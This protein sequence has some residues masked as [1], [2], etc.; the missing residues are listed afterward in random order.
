[1]AV[2][3]DANNEAGVAVSDP[4]NPTNQ[5]MRFLWQQGA[6]TQYDSNT[7][8]KAHLYGEFGPHHSAEE[9]WSFDVLF[10]SVGMEFD[11]QPAIIMQLH[12]VPDAGEAFRRPPI[13]VDNKNDRLTLSWLYD[14]RQITPAGFD[15]W[16]VSSRDLGATTKDQWINFV[17]HVKYDPW[18]DGALRVL[19]DGQLVVDESEVA[20]GFNDQLGAYLGFGIY[21]FTGT[22]AYSQRSIYFDNMRQWLVPPSAPQLTAD[23]NFSSVVNDIDLTIWEAGFSTGTTHGQGDADLDNDVDGLDFLAL[24][25]QF[26]F[27]SSI[28]PITTAIPE[29]SALALIVAGMMGTLLLRRN[30]CHLETL[31]TPTR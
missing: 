10:P 2:C 25:R 14:E 16:D 24:Q 11:P 27:G 7:Q 5:A 30:R 28:A 9:I 18:G 4:L 6:G 26:D 22:S 21:Q 29:P 12:G 15:D 31:Y 3:S 13:A 8:K 23:F 20:I 19:R 17:F 1:M